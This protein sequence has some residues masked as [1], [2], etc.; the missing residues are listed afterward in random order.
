MGTIMQKT[1]YLFLPSLMADWETGY[2]LQALTLQK[3]YAL[4]FFTLD[5]QSIKSAAGLTMS[6]D[7]SL[8][9]VK[10]EEAAALILPGADSWQT[11]VNVPVIGLVKEC[12][13]QGVLVAAICGSTIALAENGILDEKSHTSNSLDFLKALAPSYHGRKHYQDMP[14]VK[15]GNLITAGSAGSLL[16]AKMIISKLGLFR[17]ETIEEWYQYFRTANPIWFSRLSESLK[18]EERA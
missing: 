7:I 2:L 12:I 15:D 8:S 11:G 16:W 14:A 3:K 10:I 18:R 13:E 6:G 1:I 5:G 9:H 17:E 4:R